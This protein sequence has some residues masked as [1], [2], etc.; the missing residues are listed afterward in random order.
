MRTLWV[1]GDSTLSSFDD[2]YYY[3]RYGYGTRLSCY[4]N[5]K[6]N[7]ENLALSGRSSL[8][9]TR[10]ENYQELLSGMKEG[11]FLIIGFG[12]NDEKTEADRYTCPVGSKD[13]NGSF[14]ESLY[15][16]YI[17]PAQAAGCTP[18][19]CTP[20]VRRT[21]T[22]EW[23]KQEL[24]ITA[25]TAQFKGGDYAQAVRELAAQLG[26]VCVDMTSKTKELYDRMGCE[27][28]VYLHAWPSD[29][30]ISVDN[31]HTNIWGARVNAFLVMEELEKAGISGLSE[32]IVN[33]R[34]D[35]PLPDK[36]RYLEKNAAYKPVVFSDELDDSKYFKDA[37][38]FKGTVFGDISYLPGEC[39]HYVLEEVPEG[40]HIAVRGNDGKISSVTDGIAMY[41]KKIPVDV[42]FTLKAKMRINDYFYNNQVSFGLMVR[43]DIYIDR[44]MPDVLGDYVAAAP[45][46]L[47]HKE[48]AWSC[49][50]RK[51]NAL[52]QGS[53]VGRELKPGDVIDVEISS[54][55]DGYAVK[56][57]DSPMLTGG[58][59]FKLTAVDPKHVYAGFFVARNA[60]VTFTDIEY[61]EN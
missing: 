19:L 40:I 32:N 8:S 43:D 51:N 45:L 26:L 48:L 59:D 52:M 39:D 58:F 12:H 29:K 35:E 33:I 49:F 34:A 44:K 31:T 9:F 6:V 53:T 57:G 30:S 10:E 13:D 47:T 16:R 20:I 56:L 2:K 54:N 61:T 36:N 21:A 37:C 11:D 3:P 14:A 46:N 5:D 24:H 1:V 25:D 17:K 27:E 22:G 41:Y 7:V 60:D 4:L 50:A 18:I 15:T 28:T 55:S 23:T 38:G 42:N